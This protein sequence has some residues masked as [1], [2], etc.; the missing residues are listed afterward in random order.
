MGTRFHLPSAFALLV[1]IGIAAAILITLG[2]STQ[3][4]GTGTVRGTVRVTK[5]AAPLPPLQVAMQQEICGHTAP[6]EALAVGQGGALAGAVVWIENVPV[7]G[8]PGGGSVTV[9]LDQR[10]CRFLPHVQTATVG[11]TLGLTSRDPVLHNVHGYIEG[12]TIFNVA[13]P[14]AG[15]V[16]RRQVTETGRIEIKCDVHRWMSAWIHVFNHPY[17]AATGQG[18]DGAFR[19][20]RVPP[21]IYPLRVWHERLGEREASVTVAPGATTEVEV[22]Y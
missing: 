14:V 16:V 9:T 4:Q 21:G 3:A 18:G 13:I 6:N 11:S 20:E 17:H 12:R 2:D 15:M 7:S 10:R 22:R 8:G 1:A 5:A 19:I